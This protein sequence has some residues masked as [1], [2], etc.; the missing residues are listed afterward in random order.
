[1][2]YEN[3]FDLLIAVVFAVIPQLVG[4]GPKYQDL[5]I[6]FRLG[7]EEPLSDFILRALEIRSELVLMRYQ[8]G[9]INNLTG[10]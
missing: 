9:N 7:S 6:P 4:L 3:L 5:V 10:K 8:K 2:H 1:M